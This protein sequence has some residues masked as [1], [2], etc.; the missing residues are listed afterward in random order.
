M[1]ALEMFMRFSP[2][3]I[4]LAL[5]LATVSS[6]GHGKRP[7]RDISASSITLMN[8]GKSALAAQ[9]FEAAVDA[10]EASL[11]IDPR[12]REAF[13]TLAQVARQ[14]G[15]PGKAIRLY[16]EALIIEPND[17][18]ALS[19]Q[20]EAMV[21]KGALMKARENL[22]RITQLCPTV[23]GEQKLLA[24]AIEKG[25]AA[26]MVSV[27]AVQPKPVVAPAAKP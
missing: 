14:Q 26:P 23:C 3:A 1:T 21:Q 17:V 19:G 5:V 6:V 10:L 15:L 18:A 4:T 7:D 13:I 12:N 22:T 20:G 25:A 24:A 27:Q 16:R 8:E 11:A 9:K 2:R